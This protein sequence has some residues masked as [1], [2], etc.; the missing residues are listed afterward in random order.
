MDISKRNHWRNDVISLLVSSFLPEAGERYRGQIKRSQDVYHS[1]FEQTIPENR[2]C[3][4]AAADRRENK[5][6]DRDK[7][8]TCVCAAILPWPLQWPLQHEGKV[9]A[10]WSND[11]LRMRTSGTHWRLSFLACLS[12][13]LKKR[14]SWR[15]SLPSH[16]LSLF[17]FLS[18]CRL[19]AS[20]SRPASHRQGLERSKTYI[21]DFLLKVGSL[22]W[23]RCAMRM[24]SLLS[25]R[26]V[27]EREGK[28]ILRH[29]AD[30]LHS[31]FTDTSFTC[32]FFTSIVYWFLYEYG[33][34]S[35]LLIYLL[36]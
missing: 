10:R 32:T 34:I 28:D 18:S 8:S 17:C 7:V 24:C 3:S 27:W 4:C 1:L 30:L 22:C 23:W 6:L 36:L 19:A 12:N 11:I 15:V 16:R 20:G 2:E 26:R 5:S 31:L 25:E 14:I 33:C 35:I 29:V 21:Q 9:H 13:T